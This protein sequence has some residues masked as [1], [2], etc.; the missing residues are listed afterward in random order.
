M[1]S[2]DFKLEYLTVEKSA[3]KG[4]PVIVVAAGNSSRMCGTNKQLATLCGVPTIIHT[5]LA[6]ERSDLISD[7]VLVARNED[8][9]SLQNLAEKYLITKLSDIVAGG[10]TRQ[11]S[12]F[13][14]L[15]AVK[16]AEYVLIHDGARP[17][18]SQAVISRVCEKIGEAD[19][20]I[21]GVPVIDTL[22]KIDNNGA[23]LETVDRTDMVCV[24]TPQAVRYESYVSI[25]KNGDFSAF[26]DDASVLENQGLSVV[27]VLGEKS[28]IKITTKDDIA[29]AEF[30]L[31]KRGES[32]CE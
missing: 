25:L 3:E 17:L 31:E 10:S 9:N 16:G 5:L 24:Q 12:V 2:L 20:I 18:V 15:G 30:Y 1:N 28:N 22:K 4:V 26:T 7:I 6:F 21:C 8:I 19:G 29:L 27:Y 13:N 14:G 11:E 32:E 23:V